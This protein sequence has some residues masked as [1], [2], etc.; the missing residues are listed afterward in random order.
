MFTQWIQSR[1]CKNIK[2]W[3]TANIRRQF[4]DHAWVSATPDGETADVLYIFQGEKTLGVWTTCARRNNQLPVDL[5]TRFS[6]PDGSS[7][8]LISA[9]Y[10]RNYRERALL[11]RVPP[12]TRSAVPPT[13][14][15]FLKRRRQ[16]AEVPMLLAGRTWFC[17]YN[18][19]RNTQDYHATSIGLHLDQA[20]LCLLEHVWFNGGGEK[21]A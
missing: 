4:P 7:E 6:Q 12:H 14:V 13:P 5:L 1:P 2:Y 16:G 15:F 3:G 10:K 8:S 19:Y 18:W 20:F 21:I 17:L 11:T 9:V